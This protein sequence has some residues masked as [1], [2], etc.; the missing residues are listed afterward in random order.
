MKWKKKVPS[1]ELLR[2]ELTIIGDAKMSGL[3]NV[4]L[5]SLSAENLREIIESV[6]DGFFEE[7]TGIRH[8]I[9][10]LVIIQSKFPQRPHYVFETF[11]NDLLAIETLQSIDFVGESSC[12]A[13]LTEVQTQALTIA[14][15]NNATLK[16]LAFNAPDNRESAD[17]IAEMLKSNTTLEHFSTNVTDDTFDY[18][19]FKAACIGNTTLKTLNMRFTCDPYQSIMPESLQPVKASDIKNTE[20]EIDFEGGHK[21]DLTDLVSWA[22]TPRGRPILL[23]E[24]LFQSR[25][26]NA[27]EAG[28]DGSPSK[29]MGMS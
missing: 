29:S 26:R 27:D 16:S 5:K 17:V 19:I 15:A 21:V 7:S 14:V 22:Y 11:I 2:G 28:F 4:N 12:S 3:F 13:V 24:F 1:A 18:S 6:R 23:S 9:S 20:L 8:S 10:K 25:K